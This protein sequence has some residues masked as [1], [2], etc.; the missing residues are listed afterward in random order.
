MV[1]EISIILSKELELW[2]QIKGYEELYQISSFGRVKS[3][4]KN[5]YKILKSTLRGEYMGI[6]LNKNNKGKTFSVHRLVALTFLKDNDTI[7]IV[8]HKDCNKL[9]NNIHI[10]FIDSKMF[11]AVSTTKNMFDPKMGKSVL[12]PE[13]IQEFYNQ[14]LGCVQIVDDMNLNTRIWSKS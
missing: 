2:K 12:D 4:H 8:N 13:M 3:M 14:V 5:P 6:Q 9:N 7:K 10:S 1:A 11:L